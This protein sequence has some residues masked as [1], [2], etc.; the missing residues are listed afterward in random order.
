MLQR[1]DLW[2]VS[3]TSRLGSPQVTIS[4]ERLDS[5]DFYEICQ[6]YRHARDI[7][8]LPGAITATEAYEALKQHVC[9]LLAEAV[10]QERAEIEKACRVAECLAERFAGFLPWPDDLRTQAVRSHEMAIHDARNSIATLRSRSQPQTKED[11]RG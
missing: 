9:A 4:D 1:C 3:R 5:Q 8:A 7:N 11:E 2:E 6:Q 10:A